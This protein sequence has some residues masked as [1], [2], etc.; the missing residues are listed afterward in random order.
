[1]QTTS[2]QFEDY[3]SGYVR[4]LAWGFRA[5]FD[6]QFD[7][8]VTF[9]TLDQ[10]Q[11]DG[12]DVLAPTG[13]S[14]ITEWSKYRYDNYS[15]RVISLEWVQEF[16]ILTSI[17]ATMAEVVLNNYDNYFTKGGIS[18]IEQ[19]LLPRRPIRLLSGFNIELL[20]QFVGLTTNSPTVNRKERTASLH[21]Q[22]FLTYLFDRRLDQSVMYVDNRVDEILENL[23]AQFG[24]LPNQMHLDIARTTVPYAFFEK[25]STLGN[26]VA[27]LMK[28]E[29]GSLYMD[30]EGF[31]VF[32]NRLRQSSGPV[33]IFNDS[34]IIEYT[35]SDEQ[36][37]INSVS[38]KSEVREVLPL[39]VIFSITTERGQP[40]ELVPGTQEIFI[41]IQDPATFIDD[42]DGFTANTSNDN[43][44][45][46]VTSFVNVVDTYLFSDSIKITF[47]NTYISKVYITNMN[48]LGTPVRI[49]KEI[50]II[51]KDQTSIDEYE[52]Q[53][54]SVESPY[55]QDSST[56]ESIALTIVRH[57]KDYGNTLTMEIKGSPALQIADVV[58]VDI[59]DIY[60]NFIIRKIE[61][62][63]VD[64]KYTQRLTVQKYDIPTYFQLDVSLLDG[65][66]VLAA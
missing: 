58:T 36:T 9:F 26:A 19:Y 8:D 64:N 39:Q 63:L 61:N 4:P 30:E 54:Y 57:F 2:L 55:I 13:D 66:D 45:T 14:V 43:N 44:G 10:S 42:I 27:D 32:K 18:P 38:V 35:N 20:P 62:Q 1:M 29:M 24:V 40:I 17:T 51:E 22:D 3:A 25:N 11:L 23:F 28:A 65:E 37:I 50:D 33:M 49:T 15:D 5:S 47:N 60:D 21:A 16:D 31:I 7:D 6:K 59:D 41:R 46:S 34:N 48:I 52:E 53:T 56:A 12:I